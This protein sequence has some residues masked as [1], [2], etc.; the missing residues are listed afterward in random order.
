MTIEIILPNSQRI[1]YSPH[2][3]ISAGSLAKRLAKKYDLPKGK[4]LA[5]RRNWRLR[6]PLGPLHPGT[7]MKNVDLHVGEALKLEEG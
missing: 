5:S 7:K 4:G 2:P 6:G 3:N 1:Q